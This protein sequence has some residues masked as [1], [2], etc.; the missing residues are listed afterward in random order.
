MLTTSSS[1]ASPAAAV[2]HSS[3]PSKR[4]CAGSPPLAERTLP[5]QGSS[6]IS[7]Q[8]DR[9]PRQPLLQAY[10]LRQAPSASSA[11]PAST[12]ERL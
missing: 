8:P 6:S 5:L 1:E 12:V 2:R 7:K 3:A 10:S 4:Q 9:S 11:C